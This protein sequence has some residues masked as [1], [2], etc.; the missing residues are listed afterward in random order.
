MSDRGMSA[1]ML[2]EIAKQQF[3]VAHLAEIYFTADSPSQTIYM[4]DSGF[5][6]IW[7]GHTYSDTEGWVSADS[8]GESFSLDITSLSFSLSG[9]ELANLS[10]A[11]TK[12]FTDAQFIIRRA[13]IQP[14]SSPIVI[15]SPV[16]IW[17]GRI[18]SWDFSED[19]INGKSLL[20][21]HTSNHWVDFS[22]VSGRRTNDADQQ[23]FYSGDLFMKY[24]D[25][26]LTNLKWPS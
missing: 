8:A 5:D 21:W 16:I 1:A 13:L 20:T 19:P 26:S 18:N 7:N 14:G 25:Q 3:K 11:L 6:I 22:R 15:A 24:S 9:T 10:V 23:L 4:T 2:A 17:D 12:N